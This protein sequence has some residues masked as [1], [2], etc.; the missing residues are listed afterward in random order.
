MRSLILIA[1]LSIA[2]C[3][4]PYKQAKP[5][6]I[7]GHSDCDNPNKHEIP[8]WMNNEMKDVE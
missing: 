5:C 8:E 2:G 3:N 6:Y 7:C 1:T 4:E